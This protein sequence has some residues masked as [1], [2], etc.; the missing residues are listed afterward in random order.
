MI[1]I[2]EVK[3]LLFLISKGD[4]NAFHII[5]ESY[6]DKIYSFAMYL[7]HEEFLAEEI[8]QEVFIRVWTARGKLSDVEFFNSYLRTITKNVTANYLKRLAIEKVALKKVL[9]RDEITQQDYSEDS[10]ELKAASK[11]LE[12]AVNTLSPQQ[13]KAYILHHYKGLKNIQIAELMGISVYTVKE[14]LKFATKS[15]QKHVEAKI[16]LLVIIALDIFLK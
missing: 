14:Y 2:N 6:R 13:K 16:N 15:V 3:H 9:E 11:I 8:T 10:E 12:E 7:T 5:F 1:Q 4:Q